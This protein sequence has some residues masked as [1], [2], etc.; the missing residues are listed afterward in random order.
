MR[1]CAL[2]KSTLEINLIGAMQ[3]YTERSSLVTE[4]SASEKTRFKLPLGQS[5]I[6]DIFSIMFF[7][8][9]VQLQR[10]VNSLCGYAVYKKSRQ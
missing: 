8:A 6:T 5:S 3:Q 2:C 4:V 9:S 10:V 7:T 1:D